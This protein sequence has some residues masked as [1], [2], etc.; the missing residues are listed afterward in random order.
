MDSSRKFLE[1]IFGLDITKFKQTMHATNAFISGSCALYWYLYE[2][3]YDRYELPDDSDMDIYIPGVSKEW[4]RRHYLICRNS[5]DLLLGGAGYKR[6]SVSQSYYNSSHI[7][8]VVTYASEKTRRSIQ[9]IF[10][11]GESRDRTYDPTYDRYHITSTFDLDICKFVIDHTL[12][13]YVPPSFREMTE[14]EI[15]DRLT[16]KLMTLTLEGLPVKNINKCLRRLEKYY[17]RGFTVEVSKQCPTCA[18]SNI[19][20]LLTLDEAKKAVAVELSTDKR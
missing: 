4:S 5:F 20:K 15:V 3:F 10:L 8:N 17:S 9:L 14:K 19:K 12:E 11:N 18:C 16:R 7:R 1:A 6:Q 2:H 13:V